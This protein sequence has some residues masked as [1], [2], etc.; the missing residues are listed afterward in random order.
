M[1]ASS[2]FVGRSCC[3]LLGADE[4]Q[5][6][7]PSSLLVWPALFFVVSTSLFIRAVVREIK[8][9]KRPRNKK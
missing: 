5:T 4:R 6:V 2:V 1:L 8:K 7:S 3:W 9:L